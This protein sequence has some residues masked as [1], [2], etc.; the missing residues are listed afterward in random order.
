[1]TARLPPN[2][3]PLAHSAVG[4]NVPGVLCG[5]TDPAQEQRRELVN[6][7]CDRASAMSQKGQLTGSTEE[8]ISNQIYGSA[9]IW[10]FWIWKYRALIWQV[11]R[12]LA[13]LAHKNRQTDTH[14]EGLG[15]SIA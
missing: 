13:Q 3:R 4:T 11:I 2:F 10:I 5:L 15:C 12:L 9:V 1:M 7:I 6:K 14:G 8:A